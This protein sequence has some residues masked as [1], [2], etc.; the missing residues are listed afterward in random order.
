M[1]VVVVGVF[2]RRADVY[3]RLAGA[4]MAERFVAKGADRKIGIAHGILRGRILRLGIARPGTIVQFPTLAT[5]VHDPAFGV[6]I[7]F[8]CPEGVAGPP[9]T[10]VAVENHDRLGRD[11]F[12]GTKP[13]EGFFVDVVAADGI[14][15]IGVPVDLNG[16][17]NVALR[18][19]KHVLV[20]FDN[21]DSG[22]VARCA[23]TQAVSTSTS[24]WAYWGAIG[25]LSFSVAGR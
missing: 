8:E 1:R 5:A 20:R 7:K 12:R 16:A 6:A 11:S 25:F 13:G 24:G 2:A 4:A 14:L 15:Q 19:E 21:A 18:I 17:R 22:I 10:F 3:Q 23:S 9:V